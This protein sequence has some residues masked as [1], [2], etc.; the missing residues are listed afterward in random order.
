MVKRLKCSNFVVRSTLDRNYKAMPIN[1][2]E[3]LEPL[4]PIKKTLAD[5]TLPISE[6]NLYAGIASGRYPAPTKIGRRNFY[7]PSVLRE[8]RESFKSPQTGSN[9]ETSASADLENCATEN[10]ESTK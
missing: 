6:S 8:I 4:I 3:I 7:T 10:W 2:V 1:E 5:G 9:A